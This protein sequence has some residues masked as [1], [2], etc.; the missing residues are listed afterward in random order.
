MSIKSDSP[1]PLS[2]LLFLKEKV[3]AEVIG[4]SF[5]LLPLK[6]ILFKT[7]APHYTGKNSS[8]NIKTLSIN[9]D[10]KLFVKAKKIK[11]TVKEILLAGT[12][13]AGCVILLH[14]EIIKTSHENL[15]RMLT[16]NSSNANST[17]LEIT[18]QTTLPYLG[19]ASYTSLLAAV[20]LTKIA[21]LAQFFLKK[22]KKKSF[23]N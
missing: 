4:C 14:T 1:P 15:N 11:N 21:R 18:S 17:S 16:N 9:L 13:F 8:E 2:S 7:I 3:T 5:L 19:L 22:P 20:T 12:T 23:F 10:A 6:T